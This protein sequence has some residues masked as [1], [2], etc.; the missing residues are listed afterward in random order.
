MANLVLLLDNLLSNSKLFGYATLEGDND[1]N[2]QLQIIN[3][4]RR[5]FKP[6]IN[7][8]VPNVSIKQRQ[9]SEDFCLLLA[10]G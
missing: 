10:L 7:E 8:I 4:E 3:G 9:I 2:W 6:F 1:V 5:V